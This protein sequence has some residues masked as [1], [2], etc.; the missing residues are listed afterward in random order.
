MALFNQ[1]L[2]EKRDND[3]FDEN[4]RLNEQIKQRDCIIDMLKKEIENLRGIIDDLNKAKP[5]QN[6]VKV[7][8]KFITAASP[9]M[10]KLLNKVNDYKRA[11]KDVDFK[12]QQLIDERQILHD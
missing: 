9:E 3:L 1:K 11:L 7:V 8:E 12:Q 5:P 6:Q 4:V 2:E 10:L